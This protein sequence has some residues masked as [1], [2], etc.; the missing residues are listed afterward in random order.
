M[1]ETIINR[2]GSKHAAQLLL[3]YLVVY[4]YL[5]CIYLH[6]KDSNADRNLGSMK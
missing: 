3:D 4:F 6:S 2:D 1:I 5:I